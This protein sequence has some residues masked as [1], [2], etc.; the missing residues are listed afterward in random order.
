MNR[1][2]ERYL[3]MTLVVLDLFVITIVYFLCKIALKDIPVSYWSVY[4]QYW[5]ISV[6]AWLLLSFFLRTYAGKLILEFEYFTRRTI[7]VYLVWVICMLFY[8]FFTR[9]IRISRICI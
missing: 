6:A 9:E 2:F 8:L 4:F 7:Q 1:Q 3:Q 5:T